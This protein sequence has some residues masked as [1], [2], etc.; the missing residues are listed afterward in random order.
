VRGDHVQSRA[1]QANRVY[2]CIDLTGLKSIKETLPMSEI[3]LTDEHKEKYYSFH[4]KGWTNFDPMNKRL[5]KIAQS[6]EQGDGFLTLLEVQ[7]TENDLAGISDPEV[8]ECFANI[9]AAKR[10]VRNVQ[11]L[12]KNLIEE[13]RLALSSAEGNAPKKEVASVATL[14]L[15]VEPRLK[16]WP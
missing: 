8:K 10:L 6:I 3:S 1:K 4:I 2:Y 15:S 16:H 14:P 13:L 5:V 11:E 9:L 12:P 7:K